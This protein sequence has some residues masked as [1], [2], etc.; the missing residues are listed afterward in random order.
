MSSWCMYID[1][2]GAIV[3]KCL[4]ASFLIVVFLG[5]SPSFADT[6]ESLVMPGPVIKGHEKYEK[7]CKKCH[8]VFSK[9]GQ[10][11][12]CR[13]CHKK[14]S[15]DI[16][17][18]RGYHGRLLNNPV[19]KNCHTE[20]KGRTADIIKF[21]LQLFDH[22][23]TDF[24]LT[25]RHKN[26]SCGQCHKH[27]EKYR[28]A[29]TKC[30]VCH[31]KINP[32]NNNKLIYQNKVMSCTACHSASGWDDMTFR[33]DKTKFKL[34]GKHEPVKCASCHPNDQYKKT[35]INCYA[36]HKFDDVH[37]RKKGKQCEKCHNSATWRSLKFNHDK[38]TKF[39][40][41]GRHKQLQ[42]RDCHKQDPYKVKIKKDCFGCH[43]VDDR[44]NDRYG[45]ECDKCH[46]A[47]GWKKVTFSH[48]TD[49][50]FKLLGKHKDVP[51]DYCHNRNAY[52]HKTSQECIDCHKKDDVHKNQLGESCR[53][54]HNEFSWRSRVIFDHDITKFP[55]LGLHSGLTC[56]ECHLKSTYKDVDTKC[57][58]CHKK[59]DEH[60]GRLGRE[61][62]ICHNPNGW[63]VWDFDHNKR[64][65]FKLD[66]KHTKL[67]CHDCHKRA[68]ISMKN[69]LGACNDCHAADDIHNGQF[70]RDCARC[71]TTKNFKN[72][73]LRR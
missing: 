13:N 57:Y 8:S 47:S 32:H 21:N 59:D 2:K 58:G 46:A 17:A 55:L 71:H 43:K 24:V 4:T 18:R 1:M 48:D 44:H 35:P 54:C 33:H 64:T 60:K 15:S 11:A 56:E 41:Q 42:C 38:E 14:V 26:A 29:T 70:G 39:P 16:T 12:R 22:D 53:R 19:C 73:K 30:S 37:K 20:H 49:T 72:A 34:E 28:T 52:K 6:I 67:H 51:C 66:G 25:G 23:K 62:R 50:E 9:D 40:L 63:R 65:R 31:K 10:D 5:F 69:Q 45:N 7:T 3:K 61:C 27:G 36:C 68:V